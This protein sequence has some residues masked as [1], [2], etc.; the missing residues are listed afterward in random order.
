M[1]TNNDRTVIASSLFIVTFM[2]LDAMLSNEYDSI[3]RQAMSGL[4]LVTMIASLEFVGLIRV[5]GPFAALIAA[6]VFLTRG[7]RIFSNLRTLS[8]TD[9]GTW[10]GSSTTGGILWGEI[11]PTQ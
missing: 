8:E 3:P 11:T 5:A 6:T 1:N 4:I 9:S 10:S 2:M 7:A